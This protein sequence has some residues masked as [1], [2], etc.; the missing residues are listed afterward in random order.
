[1]GLSNKSPSL[2]SLF[3]R[4]LLPADDETIPLQSSPRERYPHNKDIRAQDD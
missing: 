2:R 1:M 3:L 4:V